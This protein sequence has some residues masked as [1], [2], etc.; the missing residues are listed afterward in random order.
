[1]ALDI[2]A[3]A[4]TGK[5]VA[6]CDCETDPFK[7]GRVD[8]SPFLWGF[9][10]GEEYREFETTD[11]FVGFVRE[12]PGILY[13]HNGGKFDW[14]FLL[15]HLDALQKLLIINGRI[16]KATIGV[17]ELRDSYN[18]LPV[19]LSAWAKDEIDYA[20]MESDQRH[21]S[22]N[23]KA[24]RKYLKSDCVYLHGMVSAFIDRYGMHL[25][26]AGAALKTWEAMAERSAPRSD[27]RYYN[28]LHPY[29]YGGRVE[30]FQ[31]GVRDCDFRVADINSAYPRAML[32]LHP[33]ET[34]GVTI[35]RNLTLPGVLKWIDRR[36]PGMVF[37]SV[38]AVSRGA[39]PWRSDDGALY[40]P[41]DTTEREYHVTGWELLAALETK[42]ATVR[43]V[44]H[45]RAFDKGIRFIDYVN[46]FYGE[47][48]KAK[49]EGD[50]KS[51]LL[52]KL[53]LN[54]LYGKWA[55]NPDHYETYINIPPKFAGMLGGIPQRLKDQ[56]GSD[57]ADLDQFTFAG[58]LG[59]WAL[60][61]KP[62][63]E[64]EKRYYNIAT[65][66]SITGWVRAYLW[67]TLVL[68]DGPIYCDTDSIAARGFGKGVAFGGALGEWKDEGAFDRYAVAGRKMYA[69]RETGTGKW[70]TASKG[71]RLP[72]ADI[73][74]IA[75]GQVVEFEPEAP[76]F[77]VHHPPRITKRK[78]RATK[79]EVPKTTKKKVKENA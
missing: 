48:L 15:P 4:A 11:A 73:E 28:E 44:T 46:R 33:I 29:Y 1:M 34:S 8:I 23:W 61:S 78:I 37:V 57:V 3:E 51:D 17:C 67:R 70:K 49:A 10:D 6:V 16:A 55:A 36:G 19:P 58:L 43:Q 53:L 12:W 47:R 38:L 14:H 42:T 71:V 35:T 27:E 21:K 32:E 26:L 5:P 65:A 63:E 74:A 9:Y 77:S 59:P 20:I 22:E 68:C 75:A 2:E 40:F 31:T 56:F 79:R 13:A 72:A 66:A 39:F 7:K 41:N 18:I 54:S 25:T 62:L 30:C 64:A 52:A 69:F 50:K 60:G 76:T 24:I 45:L